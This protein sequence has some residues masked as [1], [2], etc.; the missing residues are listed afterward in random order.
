MSAVGCAAVK[1]KDIRRPRLPG[2]DDVRNLCF[3]DAIAYLE[4]KTADFCTA[5]VPSAYWDAREASNVQR[6][7]IQALIRRTGIA[8]VAMVSWGALQA[9]EQPNTL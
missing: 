8:C 6:A 5:A 4:C 9:A 1:I 2:C 3:A 7:F